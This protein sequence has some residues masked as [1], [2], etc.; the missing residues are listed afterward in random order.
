MKRFLVADDNANLRSALRLMLE[1][2]LKTSQVFEAADQ[3][4]LIDQCLAHA[5]D[6]LILD[7]E[8]PGF[9]EAH[10]LTALRDLLPTLKIIVISARPEAAQA[11]A[12]AHADAFICKTDPPSEIL[13]AIQHLRGKD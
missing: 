3:A 4:A 8:L 1:T 2:R 13:N 9:S 11:A 5:P 7:W 10:H 6:C 12:S